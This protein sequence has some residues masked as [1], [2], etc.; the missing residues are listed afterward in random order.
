ME[1]IIQKRRYYVEV[2][3]EGAPLLLLHG[4]TGSSETWKETITHL[5]RDYTCIAVDI[6][7]HGKSSCPLEKEAYSIELAAEDM[8]ALMKELGH[9]RFHVMGYSMG[10]RLALTLAVLFPKSVQSLL[11]ESASPGLKT[12]EERQARERSDEA[13]AERIERE[14]IESFVDYWQRLPLFA[15]QN[16]LP[17]WKQQAIYQQR[18]RNSVIGL[19]RSLR[20]MGTGSQPSWW[21]VLPMLSM[22][23]LLVTGT[24]DVK[25]TKI[26]SEMAQLL[27]SAIWKEI[28]GAGHAIHVEDSEKFGTII[29]EF[30]S[31]T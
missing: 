10:G 24:E 7:G 4:F 17:Q 27:P 14:G 3:G 28:K 1:I 13:L 29:K 8:K 2:S 12:P 18:L 5:K 25:F 26:A 21:E 15:T 20:G 30:L 9:P 16:N 23:V 11:L 19:S 31:H 6:I 22:P